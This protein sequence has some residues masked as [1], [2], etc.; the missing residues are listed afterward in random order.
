MPRAGQKCQRCG[1]TI[2]LVRVDTSTLADKVDTWE[3]RLSCDCF[4]GPLV[5][6]E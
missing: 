3:E 6:D 2:R 1:E 5:P 4:T